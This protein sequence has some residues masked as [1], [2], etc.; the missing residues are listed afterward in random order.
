[1]NQA[2]MD[3]YRCREDVVDFQLAEKISKDSGYF[4]FGFATIE[5]P[6]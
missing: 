1:M 2:T 6:N 4:C 5:A 3:Y